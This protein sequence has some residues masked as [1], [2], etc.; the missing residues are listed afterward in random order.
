MEEM[1]I[2]PG[3]REWHIIKY[4]DIK[5][6]DLKGITN[7]DLGFDEFSNPPIDYCTVERPSGRFPPRYNYVSYHKCNQHGII[8][9]WWD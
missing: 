2:P 6:E 1:K 3:T 7:I 5:V 9:I 8:R 4:P